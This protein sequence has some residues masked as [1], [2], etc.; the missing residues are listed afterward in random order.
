ME[1]LSKFNLFLVHF[2]LTI[3]TDKDN[4]YKQTSGLMH[5]TGGITYRV[6]DPPT[7]EKGISISTHA[8]FGVSRY[9][10]KT[11]FGG[12]TLKDDATSLHFNIGAAVDLQLNRSWAVRLLQADYA[13]TF[14]YESTQH[15]YRISAGLVHR[16]GR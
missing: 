4:S 5:I 2:Q 15:N 1:T 6:T 7:T 8:L 3:Y 9:T 12:N 16:L 10:Q 11:S 13:P 14:F